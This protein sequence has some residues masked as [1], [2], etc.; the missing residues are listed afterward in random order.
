MNSPT[1]KSIDATKDADA[2]G[3]RRSSGSGAAKFSGLM[4]QKRNSSDVSATARKASF[5]EQ[6]PASGFV[7]QIWN[8]FTKGT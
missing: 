2:S 4:N 1:R 6:K 5:A 3:R 8:N 7:G